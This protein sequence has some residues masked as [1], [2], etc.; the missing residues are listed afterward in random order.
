MNFNAMEARAKTDLF[1][2]GNSYWVKEAEKA[3]R[4]A[5]ERGLYT[6]NAE[7]PRAEGEYLRTKGYKVNY[8]FT[9]KPALAIIEW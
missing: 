1:K 4:L 3:I 5:C 7:L 9:G 8:P 2:A 6:I